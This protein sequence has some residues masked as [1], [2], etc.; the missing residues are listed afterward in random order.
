MRLKKKHSTKPERVFAEALKDLHVPF[1]HR[2]IVGGKEVDFIIGKY[3]I[4]I[5]GHEQ[6]GEKNH[7]LAEHGYIP[8]HLH[9]S[10]ITQSTVKTIIKNDFNF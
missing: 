7:I 10:E 3:A 6:D 2:W 1:L 4:E 5:D 9:N 8:I